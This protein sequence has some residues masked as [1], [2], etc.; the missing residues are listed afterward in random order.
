MVGDADSQSKLLAS[1]TNSLPNGGTAKYG[2]RSRRCRCLIHQEFLLGLA[3]RI[4]NTY[5]AWSSVNAVPRHGPTRR[6]CR[7]GADTECE[8]LYAPA[9]T[10]RTA[11]GNGDANVRSSGIAV[12]STALTRW[13]IEVH[14]LACRSVYRK[15]L[16]CCQLAES[17]L[18]A[19]EIG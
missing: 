12:A 19:T 13:N 1:A 11:Q 3:V 4:Q 16:H 2:H 6:R 9:A 18:S 5:A 10:S 7:C 17:C 15:M 14:E 8:T